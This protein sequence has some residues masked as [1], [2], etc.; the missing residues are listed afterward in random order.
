M[1][2][3]DRPDLP[4]RPNRRD[5]P[6]P[7]ALPAPP[8]PMATA[9]MFHPYRRVTII[10]SHQPKGIPM[11]ISDA[12]LNSLKMQIET[13]QLFFRHAAVLAQDLETHTAV[14]NRAWA[15]LTSAMTALR[16]ITESLT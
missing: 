6:P 14:P 5:K 10:Y 16:T 15:N 2:E 13:A 9:V 3:L 11:P 4:E 1:P 12:D 7:T 8:T